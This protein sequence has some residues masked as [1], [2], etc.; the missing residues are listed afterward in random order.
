MKHEPTYAQDVDPTALD[1][2]R[3]YVVDRFEMFAGFKRWLSVHRDGN[4]EAAMVKRVRRRPSTIRDG[5]RRERRRRRLCG[6]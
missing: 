3:V 4:D 2:P 5:R 6:A 1:D